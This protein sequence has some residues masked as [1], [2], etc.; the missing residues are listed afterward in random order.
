MA[1]NIKRVIPDVASGAI[2]YLSGHYHN[3]GIEEFS[4]TS[5][6]TIPT[7]AKFYKNKDGH[8]IFEL[9]KATAATVPHPSDR[10]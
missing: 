1:L 8:F 5:D 3:Y 7:Q 4:T 10:I 2:E 9:P 6:Q